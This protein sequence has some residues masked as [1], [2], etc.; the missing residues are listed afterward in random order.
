[1]HCCNF[2]KIVRTRQVF[3]CDRSGRLLVLLCPFSTALWMICAAEE[4]RS[5]CRTPFGKLDRAITTFL[6]QHSIGSNPDFRCCIRWLCLVFHRNSV[7]VG[8]IDGTSHACRM[9]CAQRR[10]R[11]CIRCSNNSIKGH[12]KI[13]RGEQLLNRPSAILA[14]SVEQSA[15]TRASDTYGRREG[16]LIPICK[17]A[18]S[19]GAPAS[20][21]STS[22]AF[23]I[24]LNFSGSPPLSG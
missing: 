2:F 17:A 16:S 7:P 12:V 9:G 8:Y 5:D 20:R 10:L 14:A 21:S 18:A 19:G 1:M 15:R 22:A 3:H 23:D 4:R 24:I 6:F 13:V 11:R